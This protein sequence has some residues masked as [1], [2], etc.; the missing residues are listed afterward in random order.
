MENTITIN[1]E[2][3]ELLEAV[4]SHDDCPSW[5]R[6]VIWDGF[7]DRIDGLSLTA[8]YF[9][10]AFEEV[11]DVADCRFCGQPIFSHSLAWH[12]T[13][14]EMEKAESSPGSVETGDEAEE[15][16]DINVL[17]NQLSSIMKNDLL[18]TGLF[19]VI[20][21]ELSEVPSDWRTPENVL[22]NLQE[23]RKKESDE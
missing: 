20:A 6:N 18:P 22:F 2:L 16:Q 19:N 13:C 21:D 11:K 15:N 14:Q 7:N 8:S 5:L 23:M 1:N 3:P 9:R 4:C 17:A 10:Y 12:K